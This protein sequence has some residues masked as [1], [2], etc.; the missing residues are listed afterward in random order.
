LAGGLPAAGQ[1]PRSGRFVREH[2]FDEVV[3]GRFRVN[4]PEAVLHPSFGRRSETRQSGMMQI[5]MEEDLFQ[6]EGA[7]L[8]AELWG[9]HH[10]TRNKRVTLNG[11]TTYAIPEVGTA[12]GYLTHQYPVIPLK[13]TDLVNGLN[14][15]QFA[16]DQGASFWG[17]F[18]VENAALRAV[19]KRDH[20]DLVKSGLAGFDATVV[21]RP[22][23]GESL[24]I[25]LQPGH[26]AISRVEFQG[27][28]EGYDENGDGLAKD[29]HGFTK[30]RTPVAILGTA[31][32]A[33]FRISW[34]T[35]M[36]PDQ[37]EMAVRAVVRFRHQPGLLYLTPPQPVAMPARTSAV[38]RQFL[39][40]DVP[41]AFTSRLN[42]V[43]T[44]S[45]PLDVPPA[46]VER[47]ELHVVIWDGGRGTVE[48]YFTL[49]GKGLPVARDGRHD[50]I[51]SRLPIDP[52]LLVRGTNRI[53]LRSD[54]EH[55]GLEV[56]LPGPALIIR[57]K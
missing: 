12:D 6:L 30:A 33:P 27:Y 32:Q 10:H 7:E 22:G 36:L 47:A 39:C 54:T 40:G 55:H 56:L 51:Y 5:R 2:W 8:Y 18:I 11:R 17:H 28:Y 24:E 1:K 14:A 57:S 42:R 29:W 48:D 46:S 41:A 31:E 44:C 45:I 50:T 13:L 53:E 43:K 19:L 20:P 3:K 16:C 9:G 49:N 21:F 25:R 37:G 52:K 23:R 34:D 26:A 15:V 38:V 35:S 4:A